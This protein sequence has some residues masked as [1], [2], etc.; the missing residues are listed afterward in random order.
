[1]AALR[2]RMLELHLLLVSEDHHNPYK[3]CSCNTATLLRK[4]EACDFEIE[5]K[6]KLEA[7][8]G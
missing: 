6:L 7:L 3:D 2:G 4:L 5:Q 8:T 1:M